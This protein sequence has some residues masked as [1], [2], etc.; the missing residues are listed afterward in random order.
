MVD[1]GTT[2]EVGTGRARAR[3]STRRRLDAFRWRWVGAPLPL[4]LVALAAVC[5]VALTRGAASIPVGAM[6]RIVLIVY[7]SLGRSSTAA[8]SRSRGSASCWMSGCLRAAAV[9]EQLA[10]AGASYQG[11]FRNPLANPYLLGVAEGAALG[12]TIVILS[13]LGTGGYGFGPV[14]LAAFAGGGLT[15]LVVYALSRGAGGGASPTTL[16]LA[17][18]ALSALLSAVT[19]FLMMGA[20]QRAQA[21]FAFL[22]GT[23]N[24]SSWERL[25]WGAPYLVVG[26]AVV[27]AHARVLNVLQLDEE[28]AQQLGVNVTRAKLIVLGASSLM[29]T[30]A[31]AIAGVIGFVGLIVPHV[32][33]L[34]WGGDY[35][36]VLPLSAI[37]GA[38]FLVA[39]DTLGRTVLAP[40]EVPVGII[41]A[42]AGAPFFLYLL[43]SHRMSGL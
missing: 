25:A 40:Q 14:P 7:R 33:R 19:S 9:A 20:G 29:A 1:A 28:Q 15:M 3:T 32:V 24:I 6:L 43:R 18:V 27:L 22:F 38:A 21:V 37:L 26:G 16:I 30:T 35:R 39:T 36:G 31:V 41:T 12:A 10:L 42:I 4:T 11:V 17:G 34:L 23:L 5:A 13:P 8:P 2:R